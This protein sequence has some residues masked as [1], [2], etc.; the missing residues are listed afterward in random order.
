MSYSF[1]SL[2]DQAQFDV[3]QSAQTEAIELQGA[4]SSSLAAAVSAYAAFANC[5]S[6]QV[7]GPSADLTAGTF[8]EFLIAGGVGAHVLAGGEGRDMFA[9]GG[10]N[11]TS[12][13]VVQNFQT[14]T[15]GDRLLIVPAAVRTAYFSLDATES[16][17]VSYSVDTAGYNHVTLSGVSVDALSLYD[18]LLGLDTANF[19]NM[20]RGAT[21]VLETV[22]PRDYDGWT[23]VRN[24]VGSDYDD[25]LTG[26][27]Q[28]NVIVGG[29]GNDT[30]AGGAGNDILD[31][32][33]GANTV[34]YASD[35]GA[36]IADLTSGIAHT[37]FGGS[38]VLHNIQ[39]I[40]GS[41]GG[42][43]LIGDERSNVLEGGRGDDTLTG[44]AGNDVLFG[45]L[46]SD[47]AVYDGL[48]V[49]YVFLTDAEG[50]TTV[51]DAIT[52]R[53]GTDTLYRVEFLRFADRTVK[54]NAPPIAHEDEIVTG[55][56]STVTLSSAIVL[57]NDTDVD[58]GD[59]K[60]LVS[61]SSTSSTGAAVSVQGGNIIYDPGSLFQSL[62]AGETTTSTFTYTMRDGAGAAST[63]TVTMT[64]VGANDAPV[65]H[66]DLA[67]TDEDAVVTL[68]VSELLSN[69]TDADV[70]DT[71][72][73]VSVSQISM[74]GAAVGLQDGK[75]I[76]DPG[77]LFQT[78]NVGETATD[79]FTYTMRDAAGATSTAT[80]RVTVR[81]VLVGDDR[82]NVLT[83]SAHDDTVNGGGGNDWLIGGAG[84]DTLIGGAGIDTAVYSTS[85][86][87]SR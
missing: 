34:S 6:A 58:D 28:D 49:E 14:G 61:V 54:V 29:G 32:G 35:P 76:Y 72:A 67:A 43:V 4:T 59:T 39:N 50:M 74:K 24:L 85:G 69:D 42:D 36:V 7:A 70:G 51:T 62:G 11:D 73:L 79:S 30:L 56:G 12:G 10:W 8:G 82:D 64:I 17:V 86:A 78:L 27:R 21:V 47:T 83:G 2:V 45:G 22:M 63:A 15:I 20:S 60:S 13:A 52:E 33:L 84:G 40:V 55:A 9:F 65:A 71:K 46:G 23:H 38:Q 81:G 57:G 16:V 87:A 41:A 19:N 75:V 80:V 18:N 68:S 31:G 3:L 53:D 37:G 77:S 5:S 48:A 1:Y 66:D 44:G 26:D 25:V